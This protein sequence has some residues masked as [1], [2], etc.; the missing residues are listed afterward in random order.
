VVACSILAIDVTLQTFPGRHNGILALLICIV[1]ALGCSATRLPPL[2]K[3]PIN[4]ITVKVKLV[5][6][7]M[8]GNASGRGGCHSTWRRFLVRRCLRVGC[9][10]N[11]LHDSVVAPRPCLPRAVVVR[12]LQDRQHSAQCLFVGQ[13]GG[14]SKFRID[15]LTSR[16]TQPLPN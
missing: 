16:E 1:V 10:C 3:L 9:L 12:C 2:P 8:S 5:C 11:Q 4:A 7:S 15:R 14:K 6:C 13:F